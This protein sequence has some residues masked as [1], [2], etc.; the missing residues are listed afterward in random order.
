MVARTAH[1]ERRASRQ[2][3]PAEAARASVGPPAQGVGRVRHAPAQC[4]DAADGRSPKGI[5]TASDK[6]ALA[7]EA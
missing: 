2:G 3:S 4:S 6:R 5:F 7:H 1:A